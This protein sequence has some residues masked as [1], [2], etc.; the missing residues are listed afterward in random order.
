LD[1]INASTAWNTTTGSSCIKVAIISNGVS[2][3]H[4]EFIGTTIADSYNVNTGQSGANQSGGDAT[5][6]AGVIFANHNYAQ[7][8]GIAP[9]VSMMNLSIV[10]AGAEYLLE[11]MSIAINYAVNNDADVIHDSYNIR[12]SIPYPLLENAINNALNAGLVVVFPSGD[13]FDGL[14][15]FTY[16]A[17]INS[18]FLVVGSIKDN[19]TRTNSSCYGEVLDIVAPGQDIYSSYASQFNMINGY[20]TG[21]GT[22]LAAAHVS[23]VAA[24]MLSANSN[25]TA[26]QVARIIKGTAQKVGGYNYQY[27]AD[28]LN[29]TWN[30]EMGH[31]LVDAAAAVSAAA[32]TPSHDFYVRDNAADNGAEPNTTTGSVSTS[33]DIMIYELNGN[34]ANTLISGTQYK[35][36]VTVHNKGA[37]GTL[38]PTNV[39]VHWTVETS[40]LQ[41]GNSWTNAGTICGVSKS[42]T[43]SLPQNAFYLCPTVSTNGSAVVSIPWTAPSFYSLNC[44]APVGTTLQ[45]TMVAEVVDGGL[46]IGKTATDFPLDHYV[47]TNNNVARKTFTLQIDPNQGSLAISPNPTSGQTVV[48]CELSDDIVEATV[49]IS[50]LTGHMVNTFNVTQNSLERTINMQQLPSGQYVVQLIYHGNVLDS[51]QL[52]VE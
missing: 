19:Y 34:V 2:E 22:P 13:Y 31:G 14:N 6:Q 43:A 30:V 46:T 52:I 42:G 32:A 9:D 20:I 8:D 50:S 48:S 26:G 18:D 25:L 5:M 3:S 16:P 11:R 29:G 15:I 4:Q 24:L 39:K 17:N 1:A 7:I 37:A 21:F 23:G 41:W 33:P 49:T 36:K 38:C 45:V 10:D 40:N 12:R 27:S 28:H 35:I 47:R 44:P 51:K